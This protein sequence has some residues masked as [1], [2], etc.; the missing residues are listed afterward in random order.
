MVAILRLNSRFKASRR[1]IYNIHSIPREIKCANSSN[2]TLDLGVSVRWNLLRRRKREKANGGKKKPGGKQA[3]SECGEWDQGYFH[4][5]SNLY[6]DL[7]RL[8]WKCN[9]TKSSNDWSNRRAGRNEIQGERFCTWDVVGPCTSFPSGPRIDSSV[10]VAV[11]GK[12]LK[13]NVK[14]LTWRQR[15]REVVKGRRGLRVEMKLFRKA[16]G[17]D[18]TVANNLQNPGCTEAAMASITPQ[19]AIWHI[20]GSREAP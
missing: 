19:R 6:T 4:Q 17:E 9:F 13:S 12:V 3:T 10:P 7:R 20:H 18:G 1:W 14:K 11:S 16:A 15:E 2:L 5:D 8:S